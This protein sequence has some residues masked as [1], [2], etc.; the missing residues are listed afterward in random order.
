MTCGTSC[1]VFLAYFP[2]K[3]HARSSHVSFLA[4][5]PEKQYAR[6]SHVSFSIYFTEKQ[7]ARSSHV[8]F[9]TYF[10]EK[11]HAR[12][13]HVTSGVV[14]HY[15]RACET[16]LRYLW[17]HFLLQEGT[18]EALALPLDSYSPPSGHVRSLLCIHAIFFAIW[19]MR[20]DCI[21]L[22]FHFSF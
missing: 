16:V 18:W 7:H 17:T 5:F 21:H 3:Q 9:S 1:V 22:I 13:S 6:S 20:L 19:K 12:W 2:E 8:T 4:Y 15:E 10:T 14:F 11:Q